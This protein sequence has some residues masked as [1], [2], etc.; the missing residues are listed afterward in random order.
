MEEPPPYTEVPSAPDISL[1]GEEHQDYSRY[2]MS[3][4]PNERTTNYS[5][6]EKHEMDLRERETS[7]ISHIWL[8]AISNSNMKNTQYLHKKINKRKIQ[9]VIVNKSTSS[10]SGRK[11]CELNE[12]KQSQTENTIPQNKKTNNEQHYYFLEVIK[13]VIN[14][15]GQCL[16]FILQKIF[17]ILIYLF[18][19]EEKHVPKVSVECKKPAIYLYGIK[20]EQINITLDTPYNVYYEKPK[21]INNTWNCTIDNGIMIDGITYPY[22]HWEFKA[23]SEIFK[24]LDII[25]KCVISKKKYRLI[26]NIMAEYLNPVELKDFN[27]YWQPY[28][29][30]AS[31][32]FIE[33]S[34]ISQDSFE[35]ELPL[36]VDKP[37]NKLRIELIFRET[38]EK[39][40]YVKIPKLYERPDV[41]S[42]DEGGPTV[43]P[44][45]VEWG[46]MIYC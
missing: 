5:I 36:I 24:K 1:L 26:S 37:I 10:N 41:G 6:R 17:G 4:T 14:S 16:F 39:E 22:I 8:P 46:G 29:D 43:G 42:S 11:K 2:W 30:L 9:K 19:K 25:Y 13:T 12:I 44:L 21:R 27:E 23:T 32:K 15:I 28:F 45:L 7:N 3:Q 33:V 40:N 18:E 38:D 31:K 35:A 34:F 20:G